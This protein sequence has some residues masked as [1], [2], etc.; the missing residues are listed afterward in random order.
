[1]FKF[2]LHRES[3]SHAAP[4][5]LGGGDTKLLSYPW[6]LNPF[7]KDGQDSKNGQDSDHLGAAFLKNVIYYILLNSMYKMNVKVQRVR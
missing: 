4:I 6:G 5:F 3:R 1:M 2:Q 7:S